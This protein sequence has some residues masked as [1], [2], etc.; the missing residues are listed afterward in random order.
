MQS[1]TNPFSDRDQTFIGGG[2]FHGGFHAPNPVFITLLAQIF[3]RRPDLLQRMLP[4]LHQPFLY[5]ADA[6]DRGNHQRNPTIMNHAEVGGNLKHQISK[7][8]A[9][10]HRG[11]GNGPSWQEDVELMPLTVDPPSHTLVKAEL[12]P[13]SESQRLQVLINDRGVGKDQTDFG[14][15]EKLGLHPVQFVTYP[16]IVL[17]GKDYQVSGA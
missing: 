12:L 1:L 7:V 15:L 14:T 3:G 2:A 17:I 9:K 5:K 10:G 16:D 6:G 13:E 8:C 4:I 11:A